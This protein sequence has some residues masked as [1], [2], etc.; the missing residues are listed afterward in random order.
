MSNGL[1]PLFEFE[2][3]KCVGILN[4]ID[5]HVW[6]PETDTPEK[7]EEKEKVTAL[8]FGADVSF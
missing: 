2:K 6:D 8:T 3:G 4:G 7:H 5:S 1:E